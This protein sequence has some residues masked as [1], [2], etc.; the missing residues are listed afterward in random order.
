MAG[1]SRQR[2]KRERAF[3]PQPVRFAYTCPGCGRAWAVFAAPDE[4]PTIA[5]CPGCG[6]DL[7]DEEYPR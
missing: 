4:T 7:D 3:R 2:R 5:G 1:R 6:T